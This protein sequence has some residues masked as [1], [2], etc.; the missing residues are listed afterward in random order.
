[1]TYWAFSTLRH[2]VPDL[3]EALATRALKLLDEDGSEEVLN[4]VVRPGYHHSHLCVNGHEKTFPG[5]TIGNVD[6]LRSAFAA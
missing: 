6:A 4:E 1:M 3:Y 2:D 5:I